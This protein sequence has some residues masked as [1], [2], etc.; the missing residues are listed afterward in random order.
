MAEVAAAIE[1][2][3]MLDILFRDL[4]PENILV[5]NDGH[6]KLADFG[7]ARRILAGR[8]CYTLC[9]SAEYMAPEVVLNKGQTSAVDWWAVGVLLFEL[10]SGQTPFNASTEY[11]TYQKVTERAFQWPDRPTFSEAEK[12][13]VDDAL[14]L[15]SN[16]RLGAGPR[17]EVRDDRQI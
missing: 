15:D 17:Y 13:F 14:D 11:E 10:R 7:F 5:R 4:K 16:T 6:V 12:A 1:Y 9:G 2:L 3:Q 8:K